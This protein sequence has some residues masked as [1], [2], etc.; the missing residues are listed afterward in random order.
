MLCG[1][2]ISPERKQK[3]VVALQR[4]INKCLGEVNEG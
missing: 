2:L 3:P 1:H 4:S